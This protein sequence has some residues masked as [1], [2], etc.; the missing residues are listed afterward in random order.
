MLK[1]CSANRTPTYTCTP[2]FYH[3]TETESRTREFQRK[4]ET[5]E[6][7]NKKKTIATNYIRTYMSFALTMKI[8][9]QYTHISPMSIKNLINRWRSHVQLTAFSTF[10]KNRTIFFCAFVYAR[11]NWFFQLLAHLFR[12]SW[13]QKKIRWMYLGI[14]SKF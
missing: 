2:V 13:R 1:K 6:R 4:R 12:F 3:L 7:T 5:N 14:E 8:A 10:L 11:L 9:L